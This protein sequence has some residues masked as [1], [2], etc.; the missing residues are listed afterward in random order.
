MKT[1]HKV[2]IVGGGNIS[3]TRHIP[4]L[5]KT[6]RVEIIGLVGKSQKD[7]SRTLDKWNIKNT[8]IFET[9]EQLENIAWLKEVDLAVIG[10]PPQDH[11]R[12]VRAFLSIGKNVLIEKPFV[13]NEAEGNELL[14]LA[15]AKGVRLFVMH[16]FQFTS[17]FVKMENMINKG[18]LGIINSY[19]ELQLTN[20]TRRLPSWYNELP[21][22]LFYDEAAHFLYVLERL[23]G[24]VDILSSKAFRR[25]D[26]S[27]NTPIMLSVEMIAGEKPVHLMINFNSPICEWYIMILGTNKIAIY[28]FFRDILITIPNDGLHLAKDVLS[29]SYN[30]SF[31]H[32]WGTFVNGIKM[33]SG[34][35][36]YGHDKVMNLVL[37]GIEGIKKADEID[38]ERGLENIKL[39]NKIIGTTVIIN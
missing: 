33:V 31:Q 7:I 11:Y 13:M 22:G 19:F 26:L 16:N 1:I 39:L 8:I 37:D 38:A 36:L 15:N 9:Q 21:L 20:D 34:N 17:S 30:Y 35:L 23:E 6:G 12:V 32:W 24:S 27:Q 10:V 25:K 5:Y 4:A 2:C 29:N 14:E 18:Q 28:D 3:N